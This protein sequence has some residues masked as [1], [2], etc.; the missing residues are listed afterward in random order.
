VGNWADLAVVDRDPFAHPADTIADTRTIE[1]FV[2]GESVYA[3]VPAA[4]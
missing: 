1:T 2:A 3:A 4:I